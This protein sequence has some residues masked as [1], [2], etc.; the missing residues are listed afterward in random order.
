M[1]QTNFD[2]FDPAG[3]VVRIGLVVEDQRTGD[4]RKVIYV[5]SRTV[6]L[7]DEAGNT[8][9]LPRTSFESDYGTRYRDRPDADPSID[10]GQ[11]DTLRTHLARYERQTGRKAKHKADALTEA[12]DLLG[13][14]TTSGADPGAEA[15][16]SGDAD[17]EGDETDVPFEEIPGIG[18][19]TAGKLRTQGYVTEADVRTASDEALLA[20][21][22]VGPE[23]LRR[24]REFVG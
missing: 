6:L 7:R 12:L 1:G 8:T 23:N 14:G 3:S 10:A 19:E 20:V 24:I 9:L 16:A 13:G 5:D 11:Y 21:S 4:L 22:G 2:T 17:D 18:P 15:P